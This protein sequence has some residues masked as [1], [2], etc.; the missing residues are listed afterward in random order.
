[1]LKCVLGR[2]V[3]S[4]V[5]LV[6]NLSEG[7]DGVGRQLRLLLKCVLGRYVAFHSL[8]STQPFGGR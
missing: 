8:L 7:A 4:T 3:D 1:M 2:Y 6:P 5:Y